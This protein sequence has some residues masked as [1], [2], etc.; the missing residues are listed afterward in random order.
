[1]TFREADEVCSNGGPAA[2]STEKPIGDRAVVNA[3]SVALL[4]PLD[5]DDEAVSQLAVNGD[6][7][8]GVRSQKGA[9]ATRKGTPN[10]LWLS[11]PEE[12][13]EGMPS[14]QKG[15]SADALAPVTPL[16]DEWSHD[17]GPEKK[18][19][20]LLIATPFEVQQNMKFELGGSPASNDWDAVPLTNPIM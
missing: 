15:W 17:S 4:L 19:S 11:A 20:G 5:L 16:Y 9:C 14:K 7:V 18:L 6:S 3:R 1:M 2:A 13:H 10:F 8:F 12:V